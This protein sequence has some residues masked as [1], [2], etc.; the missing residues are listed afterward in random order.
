LKV[1]Q[2]LA[3]LM[4]TAKNNNSGTMAITDH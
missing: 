1:A 2:L 4:G 3:F